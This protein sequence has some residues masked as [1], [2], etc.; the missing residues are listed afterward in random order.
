M[1]I[2]LILYLARSI[3]FCV[4]HYEVHLYICLNDCKI[5]DS[6]ISLLIGMLYFSIAVDSIQE[7]TRGLGRTAGW[8]DMFVSFYDLA[9]CKTNGKW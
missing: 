1:N 3:C 7:F 4:Y 6:Y 5:L 8:L 2:N 9:K